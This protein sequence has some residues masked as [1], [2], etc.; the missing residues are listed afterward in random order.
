M[1]RKLLSHFTPSL[2]R[3]FGGQAAP[4]AIL[5]LALSGQRSWLYRMGQGTRCLGLVLILAGSSQLQARTNHLELCVSN[6]RA[7]N[8]SAALTALQAL[9]DASLEQQELDATHLL[10]IA[11]EMISLEASKL[12]AMVQSGIA[13][14]IGLLNAVELEAGALSDI[15]LAR[16]TNIIRLALSLLVMHALENISLHIPQS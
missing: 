15:V 12:N 5:P 4:R 8:A 11:Q 16:A 13:E 6:L 14:C 10:A 7:G 2:R 3:G 1:I 9:R